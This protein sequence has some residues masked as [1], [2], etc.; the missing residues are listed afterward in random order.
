TR[1]QDPRISASSLSL[2]S[3]D[4]SSSSGILLVSGLREGSR[5]VNTSQLRSQELAAQAGKPK[6]WISRH[7]ALFGALVGAGAGALASGTM[8]NELF[9][10]GGDEDCFFHGGS[11]ILVGAG[12]G[13]GVGALIGW[14]GSL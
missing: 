14:I 4:V 3:V 7:P 13:A 9:C 5:L 12:M 11:R 2:R 8:E 10:S 1:A 6:N